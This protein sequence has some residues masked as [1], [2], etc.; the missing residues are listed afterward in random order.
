MVRQLPSSAGSCFLHPHTVR[1]RLTG[2][3]A[4][5]EVAETSKK[6]EDLQGASCWWRLVLLHISCANYQVNL[7]KRA[8]CVLAVSGDGTEPFGEKKKKKK[9]KVRLED[10]VS[11]AHACLRG[12]DSLNRFPQVRVPSICCASKSLLASDC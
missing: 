12:A 2:M 4:D 9:S 8:R 3:Q 6:L 1:E 10:A 5:E 11:T 7:T